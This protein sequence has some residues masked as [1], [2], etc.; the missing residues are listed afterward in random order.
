MRPYNNLEDKIPSDIYW[1][2]PLVCMQVHVH[3]FLEP[4]AI[5]NQQIQII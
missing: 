2:V 5:F 1:R 3:S 4:L